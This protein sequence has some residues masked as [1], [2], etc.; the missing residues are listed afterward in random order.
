MATIKL[1]LNEKNHGA[2]NLY[3]EG[4]KIGEMVVS[5]KDEALTVYLSL[6][7]I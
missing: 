6:I 3:D 2:F 1:E 4:V 7:H 5:I